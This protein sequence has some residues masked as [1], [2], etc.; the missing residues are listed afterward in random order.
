LGQK[1][2][3]DNLVG[4][5]LMQ[6]QSSHYNSRTN[7]CY[8]ELIVHAAD[9]TRYTE[10]PYHRILFDGQTKE[11]L[12]TS[13]IKVGGKKWCIVYDKNHRTTTLENAG[14]D[15]TNAY[16]DQMMADDRN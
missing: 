15:D 13:E 1:I 4:S 9:L 5:A 12:A 8:V 3:D 16:I 6:E 11:I 2:L 14:F 7:R 10:H